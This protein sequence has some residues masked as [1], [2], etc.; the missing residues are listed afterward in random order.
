MLIGRRLW[1]T[2]SLLAGLAAC[3][4]TGLGGGQLAGAGAAEQAVSFSWTSTDGG[5]S[6]T[7]RAVLPNQ[8]FEGPF[9]QITQQTRSE[10][11][12]PLWQHWRPGWHDWPRPGGFL[13]PVFPTTE[14]VTHYSGQVV[15]TLLSPDQQRMRCRF[16]LMAPAQGM[17][18]GGEGECQLADGR[19]VRAWFD[20]RAR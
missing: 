6:G 20:A 7:L 13:I 19:V 4:S 12:T 17:A 18:G 8:H 16:Q 10:V 15:A 5:I 3:T 9:F 2:C 1:V 11:L 14:F